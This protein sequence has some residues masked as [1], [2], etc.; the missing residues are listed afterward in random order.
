MIGIAVGYFLWCPA[1]VGWGVA[2]RTIRGD[3]LPRE[4]LEL[5]D[6]PAG[7]L[8]LAAVA[9]VANFFVPLDAVV[10]AAACVTGWLFFGAAFGRRALPSR[11]T[12]MVA[13]LVVLA[14]SI[15]ASQPVHYSF[16]AMLYHLPT[17][18]W[19][20]ESAVPLGLANLHPRLGYNSAALLLSTLVSNPFDARPLEHAVLLP[21]TI[22]LFCIAGLPRLWALM[23]SG[24]M[25]GRM[26]IVCALGL[27]SPIVHVSINGPSTDLLP[28]VGWLACATILSRME[29]DP[30]RSAQGFADVTAVAS[31][32][33]IAKLSAAPMM[34]ALPIAWALARRT[35]SFS[36]FR[37]ARIAALPAIALAVWGAR[38]VALSG[39]VAYPAP[40]T[41][42]ASV[43]WVVTHER[44]AGEARMIRQWARMPWVA[45]EDVP[46]TPR[47]VA[48]W[49]ERNAGNPE[50]VVP[51]GLMAAAVVAWVLSGQPRSETVGGR[52]VVALLIVTLGFWVVAGPDPRFGAGPLWALGA[53]ALAT[54]GRGAFPTGG[55]FRPASAALVVVVVVSAPMLLEAARLLSRPTRDPGLAVLVRS[56]FIPIV[57]TPLMRSTTTIDGDTVWI[58]PPGHRGRCYLAPRPCAPGLVPD[59]RVL[60]DDSGGFRGYTAGPTRP[61]LAP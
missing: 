19:V 28:F 58:P 40:A 5:A 4:R 10:A 25:A 47:W 55:R 56:P 11:R 2:A 51:L 38:G 16:D 17:M 3:V 27:A 13:A 31:L 30:A 32:S 12:A 24:A 49:V 45:P 46:P 18:K 42:L 33:V 50:L 6:I 8:A 44:A 35:T 29:E 37:L 52:A 21:G 57:K 20:R 48:P 23:R 26:A 15:A 41:C 1:I 61:S 53:Y 14:V 9:T 59:L 54:I 36:L 39:C 22:V 43:P 7:Y 34:L 60:R